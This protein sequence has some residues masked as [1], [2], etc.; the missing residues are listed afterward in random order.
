[1]SLSIS[2]TPVL[3]TSQKITGTIT[4][5]SGT[6]T[7]T[8][9]ITGWSVKRNGVVKVA[10]PT[11]VITNSTTGTFEVTWS[12]NWI[13]Q[14]A[15]VTLDITSTNLTDTGTSSFPDVSG[16]AVTNNS[17][18]V[19]HQ[20]KLGMVRSSNLRTLR[21]FC[22]RNGG[23]QG[24][25]NTSTF[26]VEVNGSPV[27]ITSVSNG[28][29]MDLLLTTAITTSDSV[30]LKYTPGNIS[31]DYGIPLQAFTSSAL[32]IS[33]PINTTGVKIIG[34]LNPPTLS[35]VQ[36]LEADLTNIYFGVNGTGLSMLVQGWGTTY[37]KTVDGTDGSITATGTPNGSV[38]AVSVF[39]GLS[40][41]FH[42]GKLVARASN[43][44]VYCDD[45]FL[46]FGATASPAIVADP[47]APVAFDL[48]SPP[49]YI[50]VG[51][52]YM[53]VLAGSTR[54]CAS[55]GRLGTIRFR[56][57]A[58]ANGRV[59]LYS[60]IGN[61]NNAFYFSSDG[62]ATFSAVTPTV[63][64]A[65]EQ[66]LTFSGLTPGVTYDIQIR[67]GVGSQELTQLWID[68]DATIDT[69][70]LTPWKTVATD[71]DSVGT[72]VGRTG[73]IKG[74]LPREFFCRSAELNGFYLAAMG[75]SG[76][77]LTGA[78]NPFNQV[79]GS[80]VDV[81]ISQ[82]KFN[83]ANTAANQTNF[84]ASQT[85]LINFVQPYLKAGGRIIVPDILPVATSTLAG[86][87]QTTYNNLARAAVT[88]EGDPLVYSVPTTTAYAALSDVH[89][90]NTQDDDGT[91]YWAAH[92]ADTGY[93]VTGPVS[94]VYTVTINPSGN[95]FNGRGSITLTASA[96]NITATSSGG[97]ITGNTSGTVNVKPPAGATSFT[98][99]PSG[100]M[101]IVMTND[102]G[103]I[104][105]SDVVYSV[106]PSAPTLD[107]LSIVGTAVSLDL[108]HTEAEDVAIEAVY[109]A[110]NDVNLAT[111]LDISNEGADANDTVSETFTLPAGTW[112]VWFRISS[113]G[114]NSPWAAT[115]ALT[116]ENP[117]T[118]TLYRPLT[119]SVVRSVV[120]PVVSRLS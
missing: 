38:T 77:F 83:D 26:V 109:L 81:F 33:Y 94:G 92:M 59:R 48:D 71:G 24:T 25:F 112:Y 100:N 32:P 79:V 7:P 18:K 50:G 108:T 60:R 57:T 17:E 113:S 49:N 69:T 75:Q 30:V 3:T 63:P 104:N 88:A 118:S 65:G 10:S 46:V 47:S 23:L 54:K 117:V 15:T 97:T 52:S 98:F 89:P 31:D 91:S 16:Q 28:T 11:V 2:G 29:F 70:P 36:Q 6:L 116:I 55:I 99:A 22:S 90:N 106:P 73:T 41:T 62:G 13:E 110:T 96:G 58:G 51:G 40:A 9:G 119:R 35:G 80:P 44:Y 93:V 37:L 66:Y 85:A 67:S 64:R 87:T 19:A 120:R 78:T 68:S 115:G 21:F 45:F 20:F 102:S 72:G 43:P 5:I 105:P 42:S 4:G 111:Y 53:P 114:G 56:M 103:W 14:G 34:G 86:A 107:N 95:V 61:T 27:P 76:A 84:Q 39:S 101:T 74:A 8:S 12:G 82:K 1:M